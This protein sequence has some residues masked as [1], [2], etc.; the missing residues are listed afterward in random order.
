M[1]RPT[2]AKWWRLRYRF[3]GGHQISLGVYAD[4][5]LSMARDRRDAARR[6]LADGKNPSAERI[7]IFPVLPEK[8]STDLTSLENR[9]TAPFDRMRML[10]HATLKLPHASPTAARA[11]PG[12]TE[13]GTSSS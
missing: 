13:H 8:R 3:Q 1:V 9:A 11:S 4:V 2:G 5:S 6:L 10:V 12:C 7:E